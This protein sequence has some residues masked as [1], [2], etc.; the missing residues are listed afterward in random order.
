MADGSP[1]PAPGA[2]ADVQQ[3]P[4][5]LEAEQALLGAILYD[6]EVF[7]R[8]NGFLK[9]DHFYDPLHGRIYNAC[10]KLISSG[11]LASPVMLN[12]YLN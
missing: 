6:N 1:L 9:A 8:V 10:D 2:G 5:S 4:Y 3:T 12:T 11:R 7:Y